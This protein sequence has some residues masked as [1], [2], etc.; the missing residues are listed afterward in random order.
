M[1]SHSSL[2]AGLG[3]NLGL[4]QARNVLA[5]QVVLEFADLLTTLNPA[6]TVSLTSLVSQLVQSRPVGC[7][8]VPEFDITTHSLHKLA[9]RDVLTQVLIELELL[10]SIGVNQGCDQLEESPDDEGH[11]D[12]KLVTCHRI[13]W[14]MKSLTVD[15]QSPTKPLRVV[16]LQEAECLLGLTQACVL[17]RFCLFEVDN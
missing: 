4:R 16:V 7:M 17:A 6:F 11:Y 12:R 3:L 2:F 8:V 10:S 15:H 5:L 1:L 13:A 9:R 14:N